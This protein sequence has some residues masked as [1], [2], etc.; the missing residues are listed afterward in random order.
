LRST[1]G[2]QRAWASWISSSRSAC[3]CAVDPRT[4]V[5]GEVVFLS[6]SCG[7]QVASGLGAS[8]CGAAA[9]RRGR[10]QRGVAARWETF[11]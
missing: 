2:V 3:I 6:S 5:D 7:S 9:L 11:A 1:V 8:G 4:S 10:G